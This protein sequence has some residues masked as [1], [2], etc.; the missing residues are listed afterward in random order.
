MSEWGVGLGVI[1]C[2]GTHSLYK[3]WL[4]RAG[5]REP[6]RELQARREV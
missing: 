4:P 5:Q 6:Q 2:K 1:E 3:L